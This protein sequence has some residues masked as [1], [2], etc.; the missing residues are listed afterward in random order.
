MKSKRSFQFEH[1]KF[2]TPETKVP[3]YRPKF[4][5]YTTKQNPAQVDQPSTYQP[6]VVQ[7]P[8]NP[9]VQTRDIGTQSGYSTNEFSMQAAPSQNEIGTMTSNVKNISTGSQTEQYLISEH[10]GFYDLVTG[11]VAGEKYK[12]DEMI[13][14]AEEAKA[15]AIY[16]KN[17]MSDF[18]DT[19]LYG[20]FRVPPEM[21]EELRL[22]IEASKKAELITNDQGQLQVNPNS[23]YNQSLTDMFNDWL[24]RAV[25]AG[26]QNRLNWAVPIDTVIEDYIKSQNP[27]VTSVATQV[28]PE[29]IVGPGKGARR[30]SATKLESPKVKSPRE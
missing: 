3:T 5:R 7:I 27:V 9:V 6:L 19:F 1:E 13:K 16:E 24:T 4:S 14:A 26:D 23:E 28:N 18:I 22:I 29:G 8:S 2:K 17:L 15:Y 25:H 11:I 10:P 12:Y 30:P 20:S 21:S